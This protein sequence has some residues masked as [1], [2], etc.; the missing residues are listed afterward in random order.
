MACS[1]TKRPD[2]GM[3]PAYDRYDGPMWRTLRAAIGPYP[4]P[5]TLQIWFLSARYGFQPARLPI[6]DYEHRLT[7]EPA[8]RG[9]A[10]GFARCVYSADAVL[11]AGGQLYRDVMHSAVGWPAKARETSGGIGVQRAQLRAWIEEHCR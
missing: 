3:M 6:P 8:T 2:A 5:A 11:F 10:E 1:A 9:N 7:G 4:D